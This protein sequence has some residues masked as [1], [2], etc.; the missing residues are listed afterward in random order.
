M[1]YSIRICTFCI[2]IR[3]LFYLTFSFLHITYLL[4]AQIHI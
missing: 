3:D 1:P 4:N 2:I